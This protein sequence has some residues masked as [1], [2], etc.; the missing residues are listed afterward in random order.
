MLIQAG[1]RSDPFGTL[2]AL[3]EVLSTEDIKSTT[4]NLLNDISTEEKLNLLETI[5]NLGMGLA[6][7]YLDIFEIPDDPAH[8]PKLH[9]I[10]KNDIAAGQSIFGAYALEG[11]HH[12]PFDLQ[13]IEIVL[14]RR[15]SNAEAVEYLKRGE[16]DSTNP[17]A[18]TSAEIAEAATMLQERDV[19]RFLE[20]LKADIGRL[21]KPF[22]LEQKKNTVFGD[23]GLNVRNVLFLLA[24]SFFEDEEKFENI[25]NMVHKTHP[26]YSSD[27][28]KI[29]K[30]AN[31]CYFFSLIGFNV[32]FLFTRTHRANGSFGSLIEEISDYQ[33]RKFLHLG[34]SIYL[35]VGD[36]IFKDMAI[37][38]NM[39]IGQCEGKIETA[40]QDVV[41]LFDSFDTLLT[42]IAPAMKDLPTWVG[43]ALL[44]ALLQDAPAVPLKSLEA[45][46][47]AQLRITTRT[48]IAKTRDALN[49]YCLDALYLRSK[50]ANVTPINIIQIL[51]M[52]RGKT[53]KL[54]LL[55]HNDP[56]KNKR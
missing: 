54:R 15:I 16:I 47:Q 24:Y 37:A 43:T 55:L 38:W 53:D 56:N 4:T 41:Q 52:S 48:M 14:P 6:S 28:N 46:K 12:Y 11:V 10:F 34:M 42:I 50:Q 5:A 18:Y 39:L 25:V 31:R 40:F 51:K 36:V 3:K 22:I 9:A 19:R 30:L 23:L 20:N 17:R 7:T 27:S 8:Y 21:W 45:T 2:E 26:I 33:A 13:R 44:D 49:R 35:R 29:H 32:D 1:L